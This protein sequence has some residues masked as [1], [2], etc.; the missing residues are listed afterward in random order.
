MENAKQTICSTK[1]ED[2]AATEEIVRH[3]ERYTS[4]FSKRRLYDEYDNSHDTVDD[5]IKQLLRIYVRHCL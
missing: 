1:D 4:Y 5:E 3:Y 2:G